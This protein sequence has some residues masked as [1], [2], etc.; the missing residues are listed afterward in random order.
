LLIK[1]T[2]LTYGIERSANQQMNRKTAKVIALLVLVAVVLTLTGCGRRGLL[3]I[4]GEKISKD[5]FY[6]RLER[7][8]VQ[9]PQGPKPAGR[10][11]IEQI[12][13]E[14]LVEQLAKEK[15]VEPKEEQISKK[16]D[17]IKKQS[18]GDLRKVLAQRGM[19]IDDLKKQVALQQAVVNL[20]TRSVKVADS[21]IQ[22]VYNDALNAKNSPFKR[23]EQIL[24]S[25]VVTNSKAKMDKAYAMLKGGQEFAA[26]A[27]RMSEVPNAKDSQGKLDWFS[28]NDGKLPPTASAAIFALTPGNYTAPMQFG[29]QWVVF[30]A[31]Q[32]RPA[33]VTA[34]DE[35]KDMLREQV[36]MSKASKNNTFQKDMQ[37]FAK[38]SDIAVNAERYK[39]IPDELKKSM[40]VPAQAAPGAAAPAASQPAPKP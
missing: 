20:F 12:I 27:M 19:T 37:A 21:E 8:P 13:S 32:K 15:G 40:E 33:K 7:V 1:S 31:D 4:N 34:L 22:K 29:K 35:V 5:E 28:R 36:A 26:V 3:R 10:Y 18:G 9:T 14:K 2:N 23:P 17:F 24:V 16:I 6:T 30:R 39:T 11:V 38:K 25:A